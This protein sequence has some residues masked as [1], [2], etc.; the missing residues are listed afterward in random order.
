MIIN[1]ITTLE[2]LERR[3]N[4]EEGADEC[5]HS[6][7]PYNQ[8]IRTNMQVRNLISEKDSKTMAMAIIFSHVWIHLGR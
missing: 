7:H 1:N 6:D 8:D 4:R 2:L 3:A 5:C